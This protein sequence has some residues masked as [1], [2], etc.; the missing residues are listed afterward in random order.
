MSYTMPALPRLLVIGG[1]GFLGQA[2]CR[3]AVQR[4]IPV[5]SLSRSG[6]MPGNTAWMHKVEWKKGD[7][8]EPETYTNIL[9]ETTAVVHAVGSLLEDQSY[10][11]F[12]KP[13]AS[14]RSSE[15]V[16]YE[17]VNRDTAD[18]AARTASLFDN[19]KKFVYISAEAAPPM[20]DPRYISTKREAELLIK[21]HQEF[22]SVILRPGFLFDD[23]DLTTSSV[24]LG[25]RF[26]GCI[27]SKLG[28]TQKLR[29]RGLHP[30][31]P[32]SVDTLAQATV[33]AILHDECEGTFRAD[34]IPY[35]AQQA[36]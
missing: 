6:T 31:P 32:V 21:S 8:L 9:E 2:V 16:K 36:N 35:L 28:L 29:M 30:P 18:I 19:V 24:A 11:T 4:G 20:V 25:M 34:D 27:S 1:N 5:T 10:K 3:A 33:Q 13:S 14:S 26:G 22:K 15:K 17:V 12:L 23:S 7:A